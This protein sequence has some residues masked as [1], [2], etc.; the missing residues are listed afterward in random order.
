[1]VGSLNN[2]RAVVWEHHRCPYVRIALI[3]VAVH[4]LLFV[5]TPPFHFKPYELETQEFMVVREVPDFE[6][7]EPVKEI[8]KPPASVTP[9]EDDG[10]EDPEVGPTTFYGA[11]PPP[12][13]P[14]KTG[15][16]TPYVVYD[17]PPEPIHF[18]VPAYP[19]LAR[20][21]GIEGVVQV[22][23]V[24]DREGKVVDAAVLFSDVT[25]SM[26]RAAVDAA[27]QCRF[28]P[29]R[30]GNIPVRVSVVIPFEFRLTR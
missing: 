9:R 27:F 5:L 18:E 12:P 2:P 13:L 25:P 28:R 22:R 6:P 15:T 26:E 30:Q 14:P 8:P 20:E 11:D 16:A 21:A 1:M 3:V 10:V 24:I 17:K 4:L 23:V 29:A 19:D 7:P